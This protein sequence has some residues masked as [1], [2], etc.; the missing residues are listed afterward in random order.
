[1]EVVVRQA[2]LA[3]ARAQI[4]APFRQLCSVHFSL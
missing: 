2:F 3:Q 1:V 4:V